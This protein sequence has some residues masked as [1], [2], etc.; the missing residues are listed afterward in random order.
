YNKGLIYQGERL[1]NW[2][3]HCLTSISDAEVEFEEQD[4]NLWHIRYPI[5]DSDE[6]ITV[7]TTRPETMLGDSGICV[8]P[9]DERYTH[10]I[11]KF[12]ILP[13]V[14]RE[15]PIFADSYVDKE[16]GSGAVKMT[17]AHDPNDFE[18]GSRHGLEIIKCMND[19]ATMADWTG[20]YAGM[21][22]F[23]ARKAIVKDLEEQGNLVKIETHKHNVGTCYRC[24]NTIEPMISKQWFVKMEPLA[25]P[26][27]EAAHTGAVNFVPER[28]T[29]IYLGWL[30]NIR[31]WCISRQL[32]WG[33]RIP[34]WYC[35]DC[36]EIICSTTD[37]DTCTKCGSKNVEQDPDVLDT[38]FSSGLW[39]FSTMGWPEQTKELEAFYPTSVL[40][41]GRD[42]IFFWVARMLFDALEFT[43]KS[44]FH[45]VLIHGLVL[46]SQGRKMSKSLGNGIDPLQVIEEYGADTLR[47]MLITGNT[48]GND[49]RFQNERLEAS[50]NFANKIWNATRFVLMN[51]EDYEPVAEEA[52]EYTLADKWIISRFNSV[53]KDVASRMDGYDLGGAANTLYEFIWDEFCD[54]YIE[55]VKP[56]LYG[57]ETEASR[58]TAQQVI[59]TV[60]R[61]T[62]ILLHPFMPFITEEIWQHLPHE[63][64][65]IMLTQWPAANEANIS[66][67]TE[68][69][70]A[71]VMNVIRAIRNM[72]SEMNVPLGKKADCI[73]AANKEDLQAVLNETAPYII[74]LGTLESLDVKLTLEEK[75]DQAVTAVV[76][77]IEIFLPLRG[78]IDMD[79]EIARLEKEVEK[80]NKEIER[81]EKKLNNEG[82]VAKAPADVIAGEK[83]KLA[84]YQDSKAALVSR[85]ESYKK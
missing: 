52:M 3:P 76:Q 47:F 31:D 6:Y 83:E 58:R 21:D 13:L 74:N 70:M 38:W 14:G 49:L 5:K 71:V 29:K 84:K 1:V 60:L 11:G 10:L 45:D 17:P 65:T 36:G 34:V 78:L 66:A 18:V 15:L 63:G 61:D 8:A 68:E 82:F 79:K 56:R 81:L 25:K 22:R 54:W 37:V 33:H 2:C 73:I 69:Q 24:H 80:V 42:I 12:A 48:P 67:E 43:G 62:M 75:P 28:F 26:A 20:K 46:D 4:G 9:D 30:E 41:T 57:K 35:Q 32:W 77:G 7:A 27:I 16:F 85:L 72:R 53:A 50:R 39:P 19:D 64:E 55:M 40:V 23:A 59:A 44:P 51:L